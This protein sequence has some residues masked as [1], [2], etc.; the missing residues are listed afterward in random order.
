MYCM[1]TNPLRK[2]AW[3]R[4]CAKTRRSSSDLQHIDP[5]EP[6]S[7]HRCTCIHILT[8]SHAKSENFSDQSIVWSHGQDV[9]SWL[10]TLI[11]CGE[12]WWVPA[13][14]PASSAP[15]SLPASS[16]CLLPSVPETRGSE[17]ARHACFPIGQPQERICHQSTPP[18]S[19]PDRPQLPYLHMELQWR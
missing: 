9:R 8:H 12:G 11:S 7:S 13:C 19:P 6:Q 5:F 1:S 15:Q 14:Q 2:Y 18:S 4:Q 10:F 3:W 16:T 17:K